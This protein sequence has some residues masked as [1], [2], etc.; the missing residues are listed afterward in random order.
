[1][2]QIQLGQFDPGRLLRY[3]LSRLVGVHAVEEAARKIGSG[4]IGTCCTPLPASLGKSS[5]LP[6]GAGHRA[7]IKSGLELA[8]V[9]SPVTRFCSYEIPIRF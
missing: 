7:I 9:C 2:K 3:L 8:D 6:S 4:K 5:R 1:M